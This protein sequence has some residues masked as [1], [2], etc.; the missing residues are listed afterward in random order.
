VVGL[1]HVIVEGR[2][3]PPRRPGVARQCGDA[4]GSGRH[5]RLIELPRPDGSHDLGVRSTA[6][7]GHLQVQARPD[8][9]DPAADRTPVG[10]HHAPETPLAAQDVGEQVPVVTD[11][12]S[13][14]GIVGAHHRRGLCIL[15]HLAER[16]QVEFAQRPG[17]DIR[18]DADA[19]V[20]LVVQREVFQ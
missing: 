5:S 11:R 1:P 7:G 18:T 19:V 15:H 8:R 9:V 6:V 13:V 14:D 10:D 2:P 16:A 17:D 3:L 4:V 20:L 12:D